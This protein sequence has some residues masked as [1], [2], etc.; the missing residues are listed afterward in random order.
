MERRLYDDLRF[1]LRYRPPWNVEAL[2]MGKHVR[3]AL[4]LGL[5]LRLG[6][7][8][9]LRLVYRWSR[10]CR[11]SIARI[12]LL[13]YRRLLLLLLLLLMVLRTMMSLSVPAILLRRIGTRKRVMAPFLG[14]C[15]KLLLVVL[16]PVVSVDE[17]STCNNLKAAKD[18]DV[19][20][21]TVAKTEAVGLGREKSKARICPRKA[22]GG[23]MGG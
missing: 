1:P 19:A 9:T 4:R 3:S 17:V 20:N 21:V 6:L 18:H 14:F 12:L 11:W 13:W 8:L 16:L 7:S 10:L 2:S 23:G 22:N 15:L 5:V